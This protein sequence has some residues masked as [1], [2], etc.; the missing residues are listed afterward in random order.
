MIGNDWDT[1]LQSEYEKPYF[2][3]MTSFLTE[4]YKKKTI[5]PKQSEIFKAFCVKIFVIVSLK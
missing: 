1:L 3:K 4:E 2:K 5:Y